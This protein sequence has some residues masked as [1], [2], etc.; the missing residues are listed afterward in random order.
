MVDLRKLDFVFAQLHLSSLAAVNQE[1]A[2]SDFEHL[3]SRVG[4]RSG[5]GGITA[6]YREL[7]F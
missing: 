1:H 3:R 7:H 5:R 6:E 2:I 4:N